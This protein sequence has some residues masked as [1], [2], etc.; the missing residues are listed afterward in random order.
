MESSN[1]WVSV[2]LFIPGA[3]KSGTSTLHDLLNFHPDI[4]MSSVKEPYYWIN[5]NFSEY[6]EK[7]Y[8]LYSSYFAS[9]ANT[10]Y[11]GESSTAY[12]LFPNFIER[13]KKHN[14]TADLKFIFILRNPIDRLYS[15]YWELKG[16]GYEYSEF[17]N[18]VLYD[19]DIEPNPMTRSPEGR[20][21]HYYQYGLYGKWLQSFFSEFDRKKIKIILFEDL[22]DA[23]LNTVNEC[24]AF[25]GLSKMETIPIQHS[26]KTIIL[27]YPKIYNWFFLATKGKIDSIKPIYKIFPKSLRTLIKKPILNIII[28]LT[29]TDKQYPKLSSTDREWIKNMYIDDFKLL[30]ELTD[31][32]FSK[33]KDFNSEL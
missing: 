13:I 20:F 32:S 4:C 30:K 2:N 8:S 28:K 19:K 9:K 14:N 16:S 5:N 10:K 6:T 11:R 12:M 22:K 17:R 31:I 24:L 1:N 15:H 33:W 21:K 18:A 7:D 23:P 26:N 3:A 29:K 25:L 27:K